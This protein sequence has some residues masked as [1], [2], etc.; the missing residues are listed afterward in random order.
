M[1]DRA[2]RFAAFVGVK[3]E[4]DIMPLVIDRLRAI[5]VGRIIV[6]DHGSTDG[7]QEVL[8]KAEVE[9][10]IWLFHRDQSLPSGLG[11]RA[12]VALARASEADWVLFM[13]ADEVPL[14]RTGSLHDLADLESADI[15]SVM[16]YNAVLGPEGPH[17]PPEPG[18]GAYGR[19]LLYAQPIPDFYRFMLRE[20]D[21]P[22]IRGVLEPRVMV[23]PQALA[24]LHPGAH[25]VDTTPERAWRRAVASDMVIAHVP[26]RSLARFELRAANYAT[27]IARRPQWYTGYQG[28]QWVRFAK[29]AEEGRAEEE[30]ERQVLREPTLTELRRQG[31][32][33]SLADLYE[34]LIPPLSSDAGYLAMA[35]RAEPWLSAAGLVCRLED[36]EPAGKLEHLSRDGRFP[37]VLVPPG[38]VVRFYGPFVGGHEAWAHEARTLEHLAG[39][40]ELP[41]PRPQAQGVLDDD[42]RYL[43]T[44][45]VRGTPL[46]QLEMLADDV[47]RGDLAPWL[48][49]FVQQL[50]A[51]PLSEEERR[52]GWQRFREALDGRRQAAAGSW[53]Q[54]GLP[55]HLAEQV[56]EW[57]PSPDELAGSPDQAVLCHGHLDED[58][59]LGWLDGQRFVPTGIIDF[60]RSFVGHPLAELGTVWWHLLKGDS[61]ALRTFVAEA[62]LP[63]SDVPAFPRLALAWALL[64]PPPARLFHGDADALEDVASLDALAARWFSHAQATSRS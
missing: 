21:T 29:A 3:D 63:G 59:V 40:P 19:V 22:W 8:A 28:W 4:A 50:Q 24:D 2:L 6:L 9:G 32:V 47:D 38:R 17:L 14:P 15:V 16:R 57:L 58:V 52:E 45:Q 35:A 54:R 49:R 10:D 31:V 42:Y 5:G 39:S 13:D 34:R 25:D 11:R 61:N 20:P 33:R 26:L 62:R 1:A 53:A 12:S 48:G 7:T 23:R 60:E 43:V 55:A 36:I 30:F 56:D 41:V 46:A 27:A 18:S 44:S 51:V 64:T 37:R